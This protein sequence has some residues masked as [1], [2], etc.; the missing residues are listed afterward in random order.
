MRA[1]W[2]ITG[3]ICAYYDCLCI[4]CIVITGGVNITGRYF[5]SIPETNTNALCFLLHRAMA[6]SACRADRG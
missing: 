2:Y 3:L 4:N 5:P 1:V 6:H